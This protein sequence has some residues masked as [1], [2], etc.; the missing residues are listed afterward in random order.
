MRNK[1]WIPIAAASVLLSAASFNVA[2]Q[3]TPQG[4]W[5]DPASN[6]PWRNSS[7]QCWRAGYWSPAM[8]VEQC[9]PDL[10]KKP[11]APA[12]APMAAPT[13][14]PPPPPAPAP[15]P[16]AAPQKVTVT[17]DVLFD[18]DKA[19][20]KPDGQAKL[21]DL[22][23]KA[24]GLDLEVVVATGHTDPIGSGSYNQ[25]LSVNR[26]NAVKAYLV[27]KGIDPNRIY[28]EGKGASQQVK[29]CSAK[30]KFKERVQCLAPNRRVELEAVGTRK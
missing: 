13:P 19:V 30:M 22:A 24:K 3:T 2:A 27:S 23:A 18:F 15:A 29:E 11:A 16:A 7:G 25:K 17:S 14:P 10:V 12:P 5:V 28:T 1:L 9:D 21:D 8:A 20:I 6:L 4:N 26:A